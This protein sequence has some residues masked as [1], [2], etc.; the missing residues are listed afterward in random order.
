MDISRFKNSPDW[1]LLTAGQKYQVEHAASPLQAERLFNSYV[2]QQKAKTTTPE[3]TA[4]E[5]TAPVPKT[6]TPTTTTTTPEPPSTSTSAALGKEAIAYKHYLD[7]LKTPQGSGLPAPASLRDFSNRIDY[8][9]NLYNERKEP[10]TT[11]T[12]AGEIAYTDAQQAEFDD[13]IA[14]LESGLFPNLIPVDSIEEYLE[15]A[16]QLTAYEE[17]YFSTTAA[18]LDQWKEYE[19][20][21]AFGS[22]YGDLNDYYPTNFADFIN[23]YDKA[24]QQLKAWETEAGPE[25]AGFTDAQIRE[26]QDYTWHSRYRESGDLFFADIGDFFSNYDQA[27]QQL[28]VW[29][30]R[31]GEEEEYALPPEEA[32]RRR[33]EAYGESRYAAQERYTE[34]PEYQ[35]PFTQYLQEQGRFS[36]ALEAW[37]ENQYPSLVSQFRTTQPELTGYATREEARAEKARRESRFKAWLP[38]QEYGLYQEY[39]SQR[40]G[41]RGERLYMQA[42]TMRTAN[43]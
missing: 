22:Q 12:G 16:N 8:F 37:T 28:G 24:N 21:K 40:P 10:T 30:Q 38:K 15:I 42:P 34:T 27:M 6:T 18:S 36:G 13:Y 35:L 11:P 2:T 7:F 19:R 26:W 25:A 17:Y 31:A 23:N 33:E 32:A 43:W 9:T 41:E 1:A 39:A 20:F 3:P 4:P 29:R 5:P 14:C